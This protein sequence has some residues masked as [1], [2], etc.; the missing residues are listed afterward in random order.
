MPVQAICQLVKRAGI[1]EVISCG[2]QRSVPNLQFNEIENA[3]DILKNYMN[4]SH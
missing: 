3:V 2:N 1:N 4:P